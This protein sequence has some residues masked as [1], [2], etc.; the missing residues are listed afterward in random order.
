[1][2]ASQPSV[3]AYGHGKVNM[4]FAVGAPEAN[5]YHP[6]ASLY[7]STSLKE[8][9]S[10]HSTKNT[11][12]TLSAEVASNSLLDQMQQDGVFDLSAVPLDSRN[13]AYRAAEAVLH[14]HGLGTHDVAFRIHLVKAVPVAGGMGGGSAD[15]AATIRAIDEFLL[16]SS[17]TTSLLPDSA[18]HR[19]ATS[20]GADVPFALHTGIAIG[21]GVGDQL[22]LL[23]LPSTV[24]PLPVVLVSSAQ[25]LSTPTVFHE[26][27]RGRMHGDYP[28]A[29]D[30]LAVPDDLLEAL[31]ADTAPIARL[32]EISRYIRNDLGAPACTLAP[33]LT[34][35]LGIESE[36]LIASFVSGSGPTIVLLMDSAEEAQKLAS[37]L[38]RRGGYAIA[39]YIQ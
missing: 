36:G 16:K 32:Y 3:V 34:K 13:L 33:E 15:A 1:M 24:E 19:I 2:S 14:E 4:Y 5:G 35:V 28:P 7:A 23:E 31:V 30:V 18:Y 6:V 29:E 10:I 8:T 26:L 38:R 12:I 9:I 39:A 37:S 20:L 22:Q 11:G 27:D 25:G 21:S 17:M